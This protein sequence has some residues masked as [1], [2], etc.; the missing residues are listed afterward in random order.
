[1]LIFPALNV[2]LVTTVLVEGFYAPLKPSVMSRVNIQSLR[3]NVFSSLPSSQVNNNLFASTKESYDR[4]TNKL[5]ASTKE[6][7][8]HQIKPQR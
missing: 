5:F 7:Y 6:S 3:M 2:L 4:M 8:E 1:M